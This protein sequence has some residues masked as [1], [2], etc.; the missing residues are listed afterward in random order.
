MQKRRS[1]ILPILDYHL[2]TGSNTAQFTRPS[3]FCLQLMFGLVE[4]EMRRWKQSSSWF[5]PAKCFPV[6][7]TESFRAEYSRNQ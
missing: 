5:L 4:K 3:T 6:Q 7:R 1:S 2:S